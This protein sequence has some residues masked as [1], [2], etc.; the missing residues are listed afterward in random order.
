M[1][2][3]PE[4]A[5]G[6]VIEIVVFAGKWE[7]AI[8]LRFVSPQQSSWVLKPARLMSQAVFQL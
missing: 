5:G 4:W 6:L 8:L 7:F 2:K 1:G 3:M